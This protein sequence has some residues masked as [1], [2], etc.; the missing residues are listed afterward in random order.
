[1]LCLTNIA[2]LK[3]KEREKRNKIKIDKDEDNDDFL[4]GP[5]VLLQA[6]SSLVIL[7]RSVDSISLSICSIDRCLIPTIVSIEYGLISNLDIVKYD[8]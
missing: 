3:V 1:M 4:Y 5:L 6:F 7:F 8:I 2:G